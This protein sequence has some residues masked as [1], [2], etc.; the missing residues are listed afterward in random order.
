MRLKRSLLALAGSIALFNLVTWGIPKIAPEVPERYA[1]VSI[2][3]PPPAAADTTTPPPLPPGFPS[4]DMPPPKITVPDGAPQPIAT[5]FGLTYDVPPEWRNFS[6]GIIGW[7]TGDDTVTYGAV[8]DYGYGYCPDSDGTL[9]ESGMTG[10]NGMDL[11]AAA[12]D[13]ARGAEVIFGDSDASAPV[14]SYSEPEEMNVGDEPA[15]RFTVH[16]SRIHRDRECDPANATFDVVATTSFAT[17]S[18]A[19]F[20]VRLNQNQ[21]GALDHSVADDII[22][23]IR[24][25][26]SE[27]GA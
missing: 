15:V 21:D 10:R 27:T 20:M 24:R 17:A 14:L 8:A 23:T 4:M 26:D 22:A 2:P 12:L 18:T 25:S 1:G 11:H 19:V 9:A 13:A 3:S 5:K 6:T 7:T 16:A